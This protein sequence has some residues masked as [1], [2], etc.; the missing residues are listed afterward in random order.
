VLYNNPTYD[1]LVTR[2]RQL[3]DHEERRQV[4]FQAQQMLLDEVPVVPLWNGK[5]IEAL[6]PSLQGYRQSYT[7][8]RLVFDETWIQ[9]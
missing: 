3:V 4:Y 6:S 1:E 5:N 8:R 2:A 7:G 9:S